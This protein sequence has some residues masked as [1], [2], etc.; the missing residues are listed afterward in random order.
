MVVYHSPQRKNIHWWQPWRNLRNIGQSNGPTNIDELPLPGKRTPYIKVWFN[1]VWYTRQ[2]GQ[3]S[4][5]PKQSLSVRHDCDWHHVQTQCTTNHRYINDPWT[6]VVVA[7]GTKIYRRVWHTP[8]FLWSYSWA[9]RGSNISSYDLCKCAHNGS[10]Q[11][12]IFTQQPTSG[13]W[14]CPYTWSQYW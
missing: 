5:K 4:S 7:A 11:P 13:S 12:E 3:H 6:C 10:Y 8:G 1:T 9:T 14:R 2:C